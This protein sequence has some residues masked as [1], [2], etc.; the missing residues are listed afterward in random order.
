MVE[1]GLAV[2]LQGGN[3]LGQNLMHVPEDRHH[4]IG[5]QE[6]DTQ[7]F[8]G[9]FGRI[10]TQ[11]LVQVFLAEC[12]MCLEGG[13]SDGDWSAVWE[14]VSPVYLH[15]PLDQEV[16]SIHRVTLLVHS[17]IETVFLPDQPLPLD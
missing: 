1:L 2:G 7:L 9:A 8:R 4:I 5:S 12:I 10:V 15:L 6:V 16:D 14:V 17:L 3:L 11:R 13:D